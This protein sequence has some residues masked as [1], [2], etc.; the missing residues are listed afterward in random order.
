MNIEQPSERIRV[1]CVDDEPEVLEGLK[2]QLRRGFVVE[3]ATGGEEALR[4]I[5]SQEPFAIVVSDMR[6]PGMD[7]ATFLAKVRERTPDTVRVLLTGQTDLTAAIAAVNEGQIFR[8]LT[9][10]CPPASFL[11]VVQ[12]AAELHRLKD[13]EKTLLERT[14]KGAVQALSEVPSLV[15]PIAFGRASRVKRTAVGI[16]EKLAVQ[17]RWQIELAALLSQLGFVTLPEAT[18]RKVY[19]GQELDPQEKQLLA[20]LPEMTSRIL[21]NIPR[22]EPVLSI[23]RGE[24]SGPH[25]STINQGIAILEVATTLDRLEATGKADSLALAELRRLH[26]NESAIIEALE[27]MLETAIDGVKPKAIGLADLRLGM[28]LAEDIRTRAGLVLVARGFTVNEAFVERM[29]LFRSDLVVEPIF[30]LEHAAHG[31]EAA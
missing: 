5:A 2:L 12:E 14:L 6:M 16:C 26:P 4:K 11:R 8:F 19:F 7:G 1:L 9:K 25:N 20:K 10:P 24:R 31:K 3:T 13:A 15:N 28:T 23:L 27:S 30:I 21:G 18:A 22:L 29:R 17:D